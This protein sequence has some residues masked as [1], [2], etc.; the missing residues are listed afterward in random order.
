LL[1][2]IRPPLLCASTTFFFAGAV[3]ALK[4]TGQ[5]RT[6]QLIPGA[7]SNLL[8]FV[9]VVSAAFIV[10]QIRDVESDRLNRKTFLLPGGVV[11]RREAWL[12]LAGLITLAV[13]MSLGADPAVR[14]LT[15]MGLA[16]G[17]AY[18]VPPLRFKG[19]PVLDMAAN[20]AGFAVVGFAMG[21]LAVTEPG[22]RLWIRCLPYALAMC[23][24][25]LNTCIPDE[26]GD[27][28][29][30][31]RTSC[32]VLGRRTVGTLILVFMAASAVSGAV[33]G[34]ILC[35]LAVVGS[36]PAMIAV[37]LEPTPCNSVMASQ[38]SARLLLLLV[39][40]KAP[41]LAIMG[42]IA[43]F[44]SRVYYRKRFGLRYP[45]MTGAKSIAP[46]ARGPS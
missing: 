21:W 14:Y 7:L 43:Y 8:L 3:S 39:C 33:S 42:L 46:A 31:D 12:V 6:T 1:F 45:D 10:N 15:I 32:V 2:L 36:L 9:L 28:K 24:I 17:F 30:G 41:L 25:F 44:G 27:R 37:G 22:S 34:E 40:V 5:I 18:S 38:Y 29:L 20:V 13:G 19:R 16:L 23:G 4:Q 11:S 26:A 35:A